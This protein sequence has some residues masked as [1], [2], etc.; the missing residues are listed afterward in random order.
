MPMNRPSATPTAKGKGKRHGGIT[1]GVTLFIREGEQSLWENG[2]FQNCYFL[3]MLLEQLPGIDRCFIVN[4][5]P[6]DPKNARSFLADAPAPVISF[7]EAMTSL[8][9]VIELSAQLN[10]DWGRQFAERGGRIVGMHVANDFIIDAER[11]VFNRPQGG[12]FSGVPY[13]EVWTLPAFEKTCLQY[14]KHGLHAPVRVMPHLWSPALIDKHAAAAKADFGY[15][16]GRKRWRLAVLE[17]NICSVKTCHLPLV[18]CDVAHRQHP[19]F[20]EKLLVFNA[21]AVKEHATF[22]TFAR[23]MD[24]VQQGI[25]TFEARF[26]LH[27]IMN[28]LADAIVSHHWENA[29]NYLYYEA[30]H[31]GYPLVH[32]STML[33]GCGYRYDD[34]DPESGAL[35]L[36]QAFAEHDA[37][38]ISYRAAAD[39]F[40]STL[41]PGNELN[42]KAFSDAISAVCG[43]RA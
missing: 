14:Y 19:T 8:N 10:P 23:S 41:A 20:V 13:D 21:L 15:K 6:G 18:L 4:G 43:I 34:F 35:A 40:V 37:N 29:Q 5:G 11:M 7:D 12:V 2:I 3:L 25:A 38:L 24:L 26:P 36:L 27:V 33:G 1:V 32:N 22:V 9:L 16:P 30:L 31:A 17:P 39:A 42:R 28:T